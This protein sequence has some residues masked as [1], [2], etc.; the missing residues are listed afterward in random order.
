MEFFTGKSTGNLLILHGGAPAREPQAGKPASSEDA[1]LRYSESCLAQLGT[2]D[3]CDVVVSALRALEDDP[4]FNAG[5]GGAIQSDRQV[6][7]SAALMDGRRQSFSGV[8][9]ALEVRHPSVIAHWLQSQRSRVISEPGARTLAEQ[10]Q[11]P[12]ENLITEARLADWQ[13]RQA[14]GGFDTVGC[15]IRTANGE[16]A[17]GTSTGGRSFEF[18]GRVSDSA[19]VAG[20]YASAFAAISATG[21]GE[22]IVDDAL[23]AR[24]ETRCRD[25]L[26][27]EAAARRCFDEAVARG[28]NYGW[29]ALHRDGQWVAAHT[30]PTMSFVVRSDRGILA[31]S[32]MTH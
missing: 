25:G 24:L 12:R 8:I 14:A 1:L 26:S 28:R 9:N 15:V 4:Q 30:T 31:S 13:K 22:E 11:L 27:L 5:L 23:A 19:T 32:S 17:A 16:L 6:R 7:V 20:N 21:I 10:L 2:C 29:I 3:L 18:P